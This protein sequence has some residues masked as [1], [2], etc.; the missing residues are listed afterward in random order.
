MIMNR[1]IQ[2]GDVISRRVGDEMVV[3]K[4]TAETAHVLNKTAAAIWELCDGEHSL[5][6]IAGHLCDHFEVSFEEARADIDDIID[7]SIKIGILTRSADPA[8]E[9]EDSRGI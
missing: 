3:V 2:A 1:V 5:D 8:I 4:N 6:D 9:G 7:R